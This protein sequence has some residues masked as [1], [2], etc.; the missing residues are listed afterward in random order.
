MSEGQI[1]LLPEEPA[2]RGRQPRARVRHPSAALL[3][4]A[5]VALMT[6]VAH[7]DRVFDYE[8]PEKLSA[9]AQPGVRVR[10]RLAGRLVDGFVLERVA[11]SERE[12]QPLSTVHGPPVLTAEIA[13]L[14]RAVADRY[15]GSLA[16]VLRFAVPPRHA[17][18]ESR[19][20]PPPD[21]GG[22]LLDPVDPS[23]WAAYR[24][25][26]ELVGGIGGP[27]PMR[28]LWLSA[29][30][31]QV[32]A[33]IAELARAVTARGRGVL[34]VVPDAAEVDR[35]TKALGEQGVGCVRLVAESGPEARY[36]AFL[37]VLGG[38]ARVVV[39]T[40]AAVF[41]PV[42]DLG[43]IIVWDDGDES[44]AEPMAPGW[45][46][47]EVA[48]LRSAA[49]DTSL[50]LG[51]SSVTLE[52]A[53]MAASGWLAS[54]EVARPALRARMPRVQ[55]AADLAADPARSGSRIPSVAIEILRVAV[56][57]G[58]VLVS[59]PRAG[60]LPM[61]ACQSCREPVGCPQCARPMQ[62][63]GP[64]RQPSCRAHGPVPDWRC[65]V[66]AG[67]VVRAVVVGV[68][69][70]AEE[71][72]RALPGVQVV[73][74]SG[75]DH[76][77]TLTRPDVMVVATPGAEP[78]PGPDGYSALVILDAAAALSRP[79]L[80]VAEEVLRRWFAA[81]SLVRPAADGGRVLVV[82]DSDMREVQALIRWDAHGYA[83]RELAERAALHLPPAVRIAQLTGAALP[84]L[85][86]AD[87]LAEE[88]GGRVLRRSGP[89]PGP[90]G[91]VT[92]LVAVSLADGPH[93]TAALHRLQSARSARRAPM[94][95]VRMDPVTLR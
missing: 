21:G 66:C 24:G 58:P 13:G 63:L 1:P 19:S 42:V 64:D 72:G 22:Q 60:Y 59:V 30:G 39:G 89:L 32:A 51:G 37:T 93:L 83:E 11:T 81:A 90:D 6:P 69:R 44:L 43:A 18:A 7:L 75:Q 84:T 38:A 29:P 41:A 35:V 74:S 17:R 10:V 8:V 5:R 27:V 48:A 3:P 70:T 46:A 57:V 78:E 71:F 20:A 62:A 15:A 26:A 91:S 88:L 85:E 82:G 79:G 55:V 45:H 86:V 53:R 76:L 34:V 56:T 80:R 73:S 61:L 16:D 95:S 14:C 31:E 54:I 36:R 9:A 23:A 2:A 4:V 94:V 67:Q 49:T 40:R 68:R 77:R 65:P 28:A 92:W 87:A 47:R 52:G 12:L 50:V 33:R 25:G